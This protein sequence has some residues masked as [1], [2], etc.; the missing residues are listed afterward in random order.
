M[1]R[2]YAPLMVA[3]VLLGACAGD[4]SGSAAGASGNDDDTPFEAVPLAEGTPKPDFTLLDTE[5][6][7]FDFLEETAGSTT[8]LFFGYTSCPDI[9]PPHLAQAAQALDKPGAPSNVEVVFVSVDPERDTPQVIR[10]FLDSFDTDFIGL[11]GDP[12]ALYQAQIDTGIPPA[13]IEE[14]DA[15][16]EYL[17]GHS[18]EMRGYAPNGLGY[19]TFPFGT[20]QSEM[21]H[22]IKILDSLRTLDD[23]P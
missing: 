4:D 3:V 6:N 19:V 14:P 22:D 15:D 5:G 9:C 21:Y 20:R 1:R 12:E 2:W 13:V 8:L 7:E 10:D 17:V 11:T 16:G 18:G 23:T